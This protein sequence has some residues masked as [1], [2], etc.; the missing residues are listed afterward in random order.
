KNPKVTVAV[1]EFQGRQYAVMGGV[2][3]PGSYTLRSRQIA[4]TTAISEARGVRGDAEEGGDVGGGRAPGGEAPPLPVDLTALMQ[5]GGGN[6]VVVEAGDVVYVPEDN[7]F[8][9]TGEVEKRGAYTLRRDTTLWKAIT[10][11]GGVT[12]VAAKDRI[13]LIRTLPSGEKKEISGIDLDSLAKGDPKRDL[14]L[15]P[16]DVVVVPSDR[17][18]VVGYGFLDFLKGIFSAGIPIVP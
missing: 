12:K 3:Q 6:S 8:Y 16:Q 11:A 1:S 17:G 7:T 13:T 9:V 15:Q 14:K 2:N 5:S 10:E 4:L 18:K